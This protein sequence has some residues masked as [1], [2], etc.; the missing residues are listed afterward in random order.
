MKFLISLFL[1]LYTFQSQAEFGKV[2]QMK[3]DK[4]YLSRNGHKTPLILN[5]QIQAGDEINTSE[6]EVLFLIQPSTRILLSKNSQLKV[7]EKN[8][9]RFI[10][11]TG[12]FIVN[13]KSLQGEDFKVE[14]EGVIFIVRGTEFEVSL[15][16]SAIDLNVVSGQI[17]A[18]SPF[19]QSFVP[20]IINAR[21]GLSFDLKKKVFKKKKFS[22]FFKESIK[23]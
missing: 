1:V 18:S 2:L 13:K 4:A 23:N 17:E 15:S 9:V 21:E 7:S 5:S 3:R 19:I 12:L 10:K 14:T 22:L 20:E 8:V 11:G 16:E 6:S